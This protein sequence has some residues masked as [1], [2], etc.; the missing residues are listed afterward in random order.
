MK[1]TIIVLIIYLIISSSSLFGQITL[2]SE[3]MIEN[4]GIT[5][6][7]EGVNIQRSTQT[8][9]TYRNNSLTSVNN[10]G[11]MLQAGD[12]GI[13]S[14]NNKLDGEVITGNKLIWNGTD[15]TSITHGLFT[16]YN[17][18]VI[19][20]YNYLDKVPMAVIRKS[21]GMTNTAGGVAY[22]IIIN[23][24]TGIVIKGMSGVNIFNN[25]LY[26]DRTTSQTSR[27]LIDIYANDS[28]SPAIT[29]IGTKIKNSIFYTKYQVYNI[30]IESECATGFESD[31]N[32]FYCESGTPMFQYGPIGN[33][34]DLTFAQWQALG[35]DTHSVIVNPNFN[36]FIDFVPLARLD[37]GTNVGTAWQTGLST[38]A[39]WTLGVSPATT[40]QNGTWQ[41]GAR[42]YD[43]I[44]TDL[45]YVNSVVE[46]AS[47]SMLEMT[48]NLSLAKVVPATSAF[49]VLVNSVARTVNTVAIS[50]NKVQLTLA[51]A[52]KFG[53]I[54][55]VSYTKPAS[56]PLQTATGGQAISISDQPIINNIINPVEDAA[57]G[58]IKMTISPN[59][60]HQIINV[61][62]QY[63]SSFSVLDPARS[64]QIIR[65]FDISGNLFIEKLVVTGVPNI[66]I[67][68]NLRSGIY[69]VLMFSGGLQM[70]SQKIVVF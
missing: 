5:G 1:K 57:P 44:A 43:A 66:T 30:S 9:F 33:K 11:Y 8:T 68:I 41:V 17:I 31:Y 24:N 29:S 26:S 2:T 39:S 4:N 25:T 13:A 58:A 10:S 54:I 3:G 46:N 67:P 36:N 59:H 34:R 56:N 65:I 27:P 55:T 12:E 7:W 50:G 40:N 16:G 49:N 61:I 22:N 21:N 6:M 51:S 48:Y 37:Y 42:I 63:S 69:S 19:V 35:Y 64:P 23:P 47:P 18:N 53:D 62:L 15:L 14:T 70:A 32:V 38:T 52:I 20:K 28:F 45:V 60:I